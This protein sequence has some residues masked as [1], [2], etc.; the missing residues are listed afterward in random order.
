MSEV[1]K[2]LDFESIV[3]NEE[4][5]KTLLE[6]LSSRFTYHS[7][8]EWKEKIEAGLVTLDGKLA[9][10]DTRLLPKSRV[11]Y[12]VENY[13]EPDV[14]TD[15]E[16]LYEDDDFLI[17]S[18]PAGIPVHHTGRIFYNTFTGVV[19]RKFHNDEISPMHRLD[20][21]TGGIML[22]AKDRDTARRFEKSLEHILLR[23]VYVAVV[24]GV[25]PDGEVP[26][27]EPLCEDA[28]S[29]IK[30]QMFPRADGKPCK[31]LFWRIGTL[32]AVESTPLNEPVSIVAAELF[33][34]RKHQI[35]AHLAFLGYPI[36]GDKI[37]SLGG[38]FYKKQAS[39]HFLGESD[40]RELGA[41]TQMLFAYFALIRL[42][43]K[44]PIRIFAHKLTPEMDA[45]VRRLDPLAWDAFWRS[46]QTPENPS[47]IPQITS[48]F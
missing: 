43:G 3:R 41:R 33:T 18:K 28:S 34:G 26:C 27:E 17:L 45:F 6:M 8:L 9:S 37:Y 4:R 30:I 39:E 44:D 2:T 16:T 5:G 12:R 15:F 42:P 14:P 31:T 19:R 24:R 29:D 46:V 20:R 13:S 35:R 21:D 25:F 40:Y 48:I 22:F 47:E 36:V 7:A 38:K 11:V 23:K 10:A 1:P 32:D